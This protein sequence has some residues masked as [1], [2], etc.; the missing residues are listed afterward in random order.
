M[1]N[2]GLRAPDTI[3]LNY[4]FNPSVGGPLMRDKFWFY[5]SARFVANENY[6]AGIVGNKNAGNPN[7]WTYVPDDSVRGLYSLTQE[8]VNGRL[9]VAGQSK[10]KFSGFYDDQWR[11]WCKRTLV[12]H[13]AGIGEHVQFPNREPRVV[14]AGRHR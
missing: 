5:S 12:E 2:R 7:L 10:N 14:F 1:K 8:S 4:D 11:C 9:T 6:V 13:L 3:K